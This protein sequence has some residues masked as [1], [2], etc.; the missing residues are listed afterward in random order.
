MRTPLRLAVLA[1]PLLLASCSKKEEA[2]P[3]AQQATTTT[4]VP[5]TTLPPPTPTPVPTPPPVW[6]EAR[7]GMTKAAV[8]AA[9]PK[10]AQR[11]DKPADF[12]QPQHGSS[13][14]AG[15]SDIAIASYEG[16][17]AAFRVLFGFEKDALNRIHLGVP[18]ASATTCADIEKAVTD[19]HGPLSRRSSTGTSLKG[20]EI[21]WTLPDQTIVL[22]CAGVASLG[23]LRAS[24]D[25][26][27][28]P[29]AAVAERP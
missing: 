2:K 21:V 1:V 24:L 23:F 10:E 11:L 8:L 14:P 5:P 16:E 12:A 25:H 29:P 3:V 9:F 28:P 4:T 27:A 6:R 7:W 18:K 15:S 13:L 26:L 19:A 22:S 20:E 17:G